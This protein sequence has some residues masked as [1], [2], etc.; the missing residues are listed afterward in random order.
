M[1]LHRR[2]RMH[3]GLGLPQ[4]KRQNHL[5]FRAQYD[6]LNRS[7]AKD[8]YSD[9]ADSVESAS[10]TLCDTRGNKKTAAQTPRC[11]LNLE[12]DVF[13]SSNTPE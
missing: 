11:T 2:Q 13:D 1:L 4:Q 9:N 7:Y 6:P 8:S 3:S 10:A 12:K 5:L